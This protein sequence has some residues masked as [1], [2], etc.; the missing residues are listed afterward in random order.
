MVSTTN[1]FMDKAGNRY[2]LKI[3]ELIGDQVA[4]YQNEERKL[5]VE[6]EY[7]R[8]YERTI[9]FAIPDGY[10]I[11]NLDDLKMDLT[12][13][14]K[15]GDLSMGF[16]SNYSLSG[17]EVKVTINEY[18]KTLEYPIERFED[19]RKVI[20]AAADFNKKVLVFQKG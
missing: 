8:N 4:M 14:D 11:N 19:F 9:S 12:Y 5:P 3:G 2:L 20:N 17:N 6:N 1:S 10:I 18:Y 13:K 7:N 15:N 16:Q